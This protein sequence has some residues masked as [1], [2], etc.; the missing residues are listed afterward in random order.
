MLTHS[1]VSCIFKRGWRAR[2]SVD[3]CLPVGG[4]RLFGVEKGVFCKRNAW[5]CARSSV[6]RASGCGPE[7]RRFDS[8][9]AHTTSKD[10]K[11]PFSAKNGSFLIY[12]ERLANMCIL[13]AAPKAHHDTKITSVHYIV[14]S[15][16]RRKPR[17]G[18]KPLRHQCRK[19]SQRIRLNLRIHLSRR[20]FG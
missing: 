8:C 2:S 13:R 20:R 12:S 14:R 11:E 7:G 18:L 1:L 4:E 16:I 17:T 10:I 19:V 5:F 3:T 15:H 6:D 9:R